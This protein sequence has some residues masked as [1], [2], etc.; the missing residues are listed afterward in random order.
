MHM[1]MSDLQLLPLLL[2]TR[3]MIRRAQSRSPRLHALLRGEEFVFEMCTRSGVGGY[4]V[5]REGHFD[6]HWGRAKTPDFAQTWRSGGDAVRTLTSKDEAAILR[7]Y[8]EG[9]YT[10]QGR[11]T[12]AMWFNEVMKLTRNSDASS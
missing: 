8:E 6:L 10:M 12:V 2:M 9:L 1:R 3:R 4:F 5:L 7:A 11:F